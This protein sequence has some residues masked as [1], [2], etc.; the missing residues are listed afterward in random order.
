MDRIGGRRENEWEQRRRGENIREDM[1]IIFNIRIVFRFLKLKF[2]LLL[3]FTK[4]RYTVY[5]GLCIANANISMWLLYIL[6][7]RGHS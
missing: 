7:T 2:S 5:T 4:Y 3:I 1:I 6:S